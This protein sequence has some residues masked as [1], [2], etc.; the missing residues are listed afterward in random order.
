[1]QCKSS[2]YVTNTKQ[3]IA[4]I[5]ITNFAPGPGQAIVENRLACGITKR[6]MQPRTSCFITCK[7][8]K[9]E[10]VLAA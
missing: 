5:C 2:L 4:K 3:S 8:K 1:V 9:R 10:K 7:T 6:T